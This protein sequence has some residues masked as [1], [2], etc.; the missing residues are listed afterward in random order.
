MGIAQTGTGKTLA[1]IVPIV[2]YLARTHKQA[3]VILPTREL[4][5]QVDEMFRAIAQ[6]FG[7]RSG[8]IIGGSSIY[9]QRQVIRKKPHALIGT[10]GRIIDHITNNS[11]HL[12]NVGI[13]VLDEADR[14]FD[15]GFAPQISQILNTVP[16][17]RQT[18]LFSATMPK[19]IISLAVTYMKSPVRVEV[20]RTGTVGE[21][22]TQEFFIVNK[23]QKYHL[24]ERMLSERA[25][26]VLIFSRTK[27]G[28]KRICRD[29]R[30]MGHNAAEIH[31]NLSQSQRKRSLEG[32]KSGKVPILVATDIAARGIDV[33][34]IDLVLNYDMPDN[35]NDYIHRAGRTGRAGQSGHA[36][37]FIAPDQ[38]EKMYRI[39]RL[40]RKK[41]SITPLPSLP[42]VRPQ[43]QRFPQQERNHKGNARGRSR[44]RRWR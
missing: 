36:V 34:N 13:V 4:A 8:L 33:T 6:P 11:L 37:S 7:F 35:P 30:C 22:I 14:M 44:A 31:S 17:E 12:R 5:A 26:T 39:E 1:F 9:K 21:K 41:L 29:I 32:F 2:E 18:M 24:L 3:L 15:M 40:L 38:R 27:Y 10:P 19:D 23:S 20:D 28:A 43:K 25:R 16:S 42:N